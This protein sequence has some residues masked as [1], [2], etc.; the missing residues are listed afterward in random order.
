MPDPF[1]ETFDENWASQGA[2]D[3]AGQSTLPTFI[4]MPD[5]SSKFLM[6]CTADELRADAESRRVQG[7]KFID[8]AESLTERGQAFIDE[9]E[10]LTVQGRKL[11]DEAQWLSKAADIKEGHPP[12]QD[13]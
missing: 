2:P 5:G 12:Q 3:F 10:S 6:E 7:R 8:E 9:V 13:H 1:D 11:I 4:E